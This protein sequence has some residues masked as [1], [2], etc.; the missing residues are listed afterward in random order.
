MAEREYTG[1]ML[2]LEIT[3]VDMTL[4][5]IRVEPELS[6]Q[7]GADARAVHGISNEV[8]GSGQDFPMA[9]NRFLAWI[10]DLIN[11]G[12]KTNGKTNSTMRKKQLQKWPSEAPS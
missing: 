7:R 10:D 12:W 5:L 8:I 9:W 3:G 2:D 1:V 4:A 11:L 6:L